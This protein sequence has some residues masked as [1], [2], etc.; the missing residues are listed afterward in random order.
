MGQGGWGGGDGESLKSEPQR[1]G[2]GG[3][4]LSLRSLCEKNA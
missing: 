4:S 3:S 1:T 2:G